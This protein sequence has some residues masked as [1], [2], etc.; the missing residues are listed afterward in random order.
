MFHKNRTGLE[1][2]YLDSLTRKWK[3]SNHLINN[4]KS[5]LGRTLE[6]LYEAYNS[7]VGYSLSF[8]EIIEGYKQSKSSSEIIFEI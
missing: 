8:V 6:P 7:K 3:K 5:I 4:N 2:L 1:Y